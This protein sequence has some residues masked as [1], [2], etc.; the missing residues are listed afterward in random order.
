MKQLSVYK[1][2]KNN[3][4]EP[5]NKDSLKTILIF[6]VYQYLAVVKC[7]ILVNYILYLK[8]KLYFQSW[9]A[10]NNLSPIRL[11]TLCRKL[12]VIKISFSRPLPLRISSSYTPSTFLN[13]RT[14][15][16]KIASGIYPMCIYS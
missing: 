7:S 1:K 4:I 14:R 8:I 3:N 2:T 16:G 9:I 13:R 11:E 12:S 10:L 5:I 15:M 6:N